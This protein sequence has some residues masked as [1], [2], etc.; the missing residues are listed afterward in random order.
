M[1]M[2]VDLGDL[3]L[4]ERLRLC[5]FEL[6]QR[7][8]SISDEEEKKNHIVKYFNDIICSNTEVYCP[9]FLPDLDW[10]NVE[11]PLSLLK[12]LNKKIVVLDFFT[13][14][15]INCMHILPDLH[16]LELRFPENRELIIVGVHSAKFENEKVLSNLMSAVLRYNISHPVVNDPQGWLWKE[17]HVICWPT[18][19]ILGPQSQVL[20]T[21]VGENEREYLQLFCETAVEY[22]RMRGSIISS[23]VPVKLLRE[24]LPVSPL[25]FPGK[26]CVDG[27]GKR[28][29]IADSGH[30]RILILNREGVVEHVIGG[31]DPGYKD[32]NF[33]QARFRSPQGIVWKNP[34]IIYVADT[35]NH[36]IR[37]INVSL[38]VVTTI[39]GTGYQ[40]TDKVG[41]KQ[42]KEQP[43][44]SPWDLCLGR[45]IDP[46]SPGFDLFSPDIAHLLPTTAKP[47][48]DDPDFI[49][50]HPPDYSLPSE[51]STVES[52][53][54]FSPFWT[55]FK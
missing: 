22:F 33:H 42:N 2:N 11:Q 5:Q 50:F 34:A 13:Y 6:V 47:I 48:S 24:S 26:V 39:A 45:S 31:K 36:L 19:V 32:G 27:V 37:E 28:I 3:S 8:N 18:L 29:V 53:K 4:L 21:L 7:I 20:F 16:N 12:N 30:H 54:P 52:A 55:C 46:Y 38:R 9:D 49:C 44:S 23:P 14:C 25:L 15:C 51:A 1:D 41:G 10:L 40:G 35:E 17:L 43:I